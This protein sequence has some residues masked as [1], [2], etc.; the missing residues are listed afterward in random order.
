MRALFVVPGKGWCLPSRQDGSLAPGHP[1]LQPYAGSRQT[2]FVLPSP[3]RQA[4]HNPF[5]ASAPA[6]SRSAGH[7]LPR[8]AGTAPGCEVCSRLW[9]LPRAV[10]TAA[11]T[12]LGCS[13]CSGLR[14][15]RR[16]PGRL[17]WQSTL[18]A[19][20]VPMWLRNTN[21]LSR[22]GTQAGTSSVLTL[23]S[24]WCDSLAIY[25]FKATELFATFLKANTV[26]GQGSCSA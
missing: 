9:L 19:G 11:G 18:V 16:V 15:L 4:P 26:C 25:L 2:M 7:P 8:P 12:A 22:L 5:L 23:N 14:A 21:K 3:L 13:L 17:V 24:Y 1:G 6:A 10:G 20:P